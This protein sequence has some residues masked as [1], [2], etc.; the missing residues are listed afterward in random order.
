MRKNTITQRFDCFLA[1]Q[2]SDLASNIEV[3]LSSPTPLFFK[4]K[5]R[6]CRKNRGLEKLKSLIM[7][8]NQS[9][10]K[11]EKKQAKTIKNLNRDM[12]GDGFRKN[13]THTFLTLHYINYDTN[14]IECTKN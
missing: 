10:E 2:K 9:R 7:S 11:I 13:S 1:H 4:I 8:T 5:W 3:L 12:G 14:L 6:I